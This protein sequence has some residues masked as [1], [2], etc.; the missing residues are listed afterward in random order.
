MILVGLVHKETL[1]LGI[2]GV[3]LATGLIALAAAAHQGWS[4]NLSP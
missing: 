1:L 4:S 2:P 3:Y